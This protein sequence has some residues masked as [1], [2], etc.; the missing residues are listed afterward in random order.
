M[1]C[2]RNM[3]GACS[4]VE[5]GGSWGGGR[6][7]REWWWWWW[8]GV[9]KCGGAEE[10]EGRSI[11]VCR[12]DGEKES[13]WL[14][15]L[16]VIRG[17]WWVVKLCVCGSVC[18]CVCEPHCGQGSVTG[19]QWV[20]LPPECVSL[21]AHSCVC[22]LYFMVA[23]WIPRHFFFSPADLPGASAEFLHLPASR[24]R[25]FASN[26]ISPALNGIF[27]FCKSGRPISTPAKT[28]LMPTFGFWKRASPTL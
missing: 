9:D 22:K 3:K 24:G 18:R 15:K 27:H 1:C 21:T 17:Q 23:E 8:G 2:E 20:P 12:R 14:W 26:P 4:G 7:G 6:N 16:V 28:P 5:K 13:G 19:R 25:K 11:G 10:E